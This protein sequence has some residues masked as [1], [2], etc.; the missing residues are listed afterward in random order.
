MSNDTFNIQAYLERINYEG[1]TD[2][3]YE[4][5][6][7][8]HLAHTFNVPF[9]N[10][11]VY[12]R[13]PIPLDKESLFKKIVLNKRGGYCFEMNGLFSFVLQ[14]LGFK[15]SNLLARG[16]R[17]G[18]T[19][20]PKTH[21]VLMVELDGKRYLADVGYGNDGIE[22]PVLMEPNLEQK[23]FHN[24]YRILEDPKV[25]Y[26]LQR[27]VDD[28]FRIMYAFTLEECSPMDY[29]MSNHYTATYPE[30][31]F[32]KIRLCTMPSKEGRITLT[33]GN[34]KVIKDGTITE[35]KLSGDE[36]EFNELLKKYFK[37]DMETV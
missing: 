4:T 2:V 6:Y 3:S 18:I 27:K 1:K 14:D 10:L 5:L 30:S 37:L 35:T 32:I 17:D 28:G 33:D 24:T 12:L 22:A 34:L 26:I 15:V 25:G 7:G 29:V 9:E 13:R 36:K 19:Y 20:S 8:I 11:D 31:L 23:H 16:T 21:Q